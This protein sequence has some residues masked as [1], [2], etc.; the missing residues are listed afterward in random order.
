MG[1][2]MTCKILHVCWLHVNYIETLII[3]L[4]IPQ[5]YPKVIRRNKRL[6]I[7]AIGLKTLDHV[8]ISG[9]FIHN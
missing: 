1:A 8:R 5:V 3:D 6:T 4:K 7:T 2:K 9:T